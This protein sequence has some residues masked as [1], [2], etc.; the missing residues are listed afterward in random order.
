MPL[1]WAS[2]P[3]LPPSLRPS[4]PSLLLLLLLLLSVV[5]FWLYN[6]R[7]LSPLPHTH[8][9]AWTLQRF[10]HCFQPSAGGR[11]QEKGRRH[12]H[13]L[14]VN[15][16]HVPIEWISDQ[17]ADGRRRSECDCR[18][19]WQRFDTS[20]APRGVFSPS[21]LQ[22]WKWRCDAKHGRR[23]GGGCQGIENY[24]IS[25]AFFGLDF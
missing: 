14:T 6:T 23:S 1:S 10:Q 12:V 19:G 11:G 24:M 17:C 4:L 2:Y 20:P 21:V 15:K 22:R 7:T 13:I 5:P 9:D 25:C 3:F 16:Q 18:H 8:T